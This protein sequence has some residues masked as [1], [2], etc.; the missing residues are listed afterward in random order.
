MPN[1]A[2]CFVSAYSAVGGEHEKQQPPMIVNLFQ[3]VAAQ[4]NSSG[5]LLRNTMSR[6]QTV[7]SARILPRVER[8]ETYYGCTLETLRKSNGI[9]I[10]LHTF[11][12]A[13]I[14]Q[15]TSNFSTLNK[16]NRSIRFRVSMGRRNVLAIW[17]MP[18]VL[19]MSKMATSLPTTFTA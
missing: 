7:Y 10:F 18:A 8:A 2:Y 9:T 17:Y 4:K 11:P 16:E 19:D 3:S 6:Y 1:L 5:N 12:L 15:L 13:R 14:D